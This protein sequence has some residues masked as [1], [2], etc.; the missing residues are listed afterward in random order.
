MVI[1]RLNRLPS[2]RTSVVLQVLLAERTPRA[3]VALLAKTVA[4]HVSVERPADRFS[5]A[6]PSRLMFWLGVSE[7]EAPL[8][9]LTSAWALKLSPFEIGRP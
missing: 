5:I 1:G 2:D 4:V 3:L 7:V 9:Q 8:R 6:K